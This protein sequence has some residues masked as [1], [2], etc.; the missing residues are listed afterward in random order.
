MRYSAI[1]LM[2]GGLTV[3]ACNPDILNTKPEVRGLKGAAPVQTLTNPAD[4]TDITLRPGGQLVLRLASNPTTGY[5][6][7]LLDTGTDAVI[8]LQSEA[9]IA[10]P[11]PEG[12]AGSGGIQVFVFDAARA[13]HATMVMSYQRDQNDVADS[14][15]L[16]VKIIE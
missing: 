15:Q 11:A 16:K 2:I 10:D 9:Y 6:W 13:G 1:A 12:V 14:L 5:Y 4:G 8:A 3:S 7:H